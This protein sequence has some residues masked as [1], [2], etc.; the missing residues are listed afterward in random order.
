MS[1]LLTLSLRMSPYTLQRKLVLAVSHPERPNIMV[2]LG[3]KLTAHF[4][5]T[6]HC[7]RQSPM[8]SDLEELAQPIHTLL[9]MATVHTGGHSMMKSTELHHLQK[10]KMRSPYW[11]PVLQWYH[12]PPQKNQY[13]LNSTQR[14]YLCQGRVFL[15]LQVCLLITF[16]RLL[17]RPWPK[18][19]IF[20]FYHVQF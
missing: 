4:E 17:T 6:I 20:W 19:T 9:Q 14:A 11:T 10:A 5:G 16:I 13:W 3:Q 7:F 2:H 1:E 12:Q 18:P 8:A 15:Q